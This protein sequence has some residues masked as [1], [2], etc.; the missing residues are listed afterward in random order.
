MKMS[1]AGLN[2]DSVT[3]ASLT[4]SSY[5]GHK[6]G[7]WKC[8]LDTL[9]GETSPCSAVCL[10][11]L[12]KEHLIRD[13]P[14][15]N[16]QS[17]IP[18][19]LTSAKVDEGQLGVASRPAGPLEQSKQSDAWYLPSATASWRM[20]MLTHGNLPEASFRRIK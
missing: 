10:H 16:F 19:K 20:N 6:M 18:D 17:Q 8:V 3:E 9:H 1:N 12:V 14:L 11:I 4:K 2:A 5:N 13:S 7:S 15:T